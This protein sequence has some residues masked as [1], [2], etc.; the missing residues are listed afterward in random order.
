MAQENKSEKVKPDFIG[1]DGFAVWKGI[2]K[3]GNEF[4]SIKCLGKYFNVFPNKYKE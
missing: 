1:Y 3:N 4:L 2:D